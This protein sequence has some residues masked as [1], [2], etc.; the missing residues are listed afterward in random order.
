MADSQNTILSNLKSGH[1][2]LGTF[3]TNVSSGATITTIP[4]R[5]DNSWANNV[6]LAK[7]LDDAGIEFMLPIAR[8]I[9][10]GG[11]TNFEGNILEPATWAAGLAAHTQ[12]LNL[13]VTVH[14]AVQ[15]PVVVAKQLA[16]IDAISG[17]RVGLNVVAGWNAPEYAALG[18]ASALP[19]AKH[20]ERYAYTQEWLGIVRKL[21]ADGAAPF[22]WDGAFW[23]LKGARAEPGLSRPMPIINAAGSGEGRAFAV[24]NADVLFT[25]VP[26]LERSRLEIAELKAQGRAVGRDVWVMTYVHVVCRPTEEEAKAFFDYFCTEN[27]DWEV[28]DELLSM[29]FAS[30]KA[31]PPETLAQVRTNFAAGHGASL[32]IGTPRQVADGLVEMYGIGLGGA[33]ISFVDYLEEFPYFRDSVLPLLEEA[34]IRKP[35]VRQD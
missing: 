21:W 24:R 9:G 11:R 17:S 12:R 14:A 30:S 23:T 19:L 18:L 34:G 5:W 7:L 29:L 31:F 3:G 22:D 25:P 15:N 6:A 32:L 1:F 26:D 28:T 2:I 13:V 33:T 27:A 16:T 4:E 35:C 10:Y 20:A 8:W